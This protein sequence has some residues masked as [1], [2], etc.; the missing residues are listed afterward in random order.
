MSDEKAIVSTEDYDEPIILPI[1]YEDEAAEEARR[2]A[3]EEKEKRERVE[4]M[5]NIAPQIVPTGFGADENEE[6]QRRKD[7]ADKAKQAYDEALARLKEAEAVKEAYAAREREVI[8]IK[9]AAEEAQKAAQNAQVDFDD[10]GN[11]IVRITVPK[12]YDVVINFK[13]KKK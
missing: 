5:R 10:N 13:P 12:A 1:P 11:S 4:K 6:L 2:K 7:E 9:L 3:A 8:A